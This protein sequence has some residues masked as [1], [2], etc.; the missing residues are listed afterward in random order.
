M[1]NNDFLR[2]LR[3]ALNIKDNIMVQIFKKGNITVTKE[4][5]LDYLKISVFRSSSDR[6]P[7]SP[8]LREEKSLRESAASYTYALLFFPPK[9]VKRFDWLSPGHR[10]GLILVKTHCQHGQPSHIRF[11][12]PRFSSEHTAYISPARE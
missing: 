9:M 5:V 10:P 1:T 8:T 6:V 12:R 2:R 11:C 3:Y 7:F 4:D